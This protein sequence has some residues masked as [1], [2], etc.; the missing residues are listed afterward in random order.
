MEANERVAS[1]DPEQGFSVVV[2]KPFDRPVETALCLSRFFSD[3][4][5]NPNPDSGE[6]D[7]PDV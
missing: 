4:K 7:E 2:G 6:R 1:D 5:L 3:M